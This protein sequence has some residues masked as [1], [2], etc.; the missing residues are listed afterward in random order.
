M[1]S[2]KNTI[3]ALITILCSYTV[4]AQKEIIYVEHFEKVTISPHIEVTFIQGTKEQVTIES[5]SVPENKLTVEVSG[6]SLNIY[7]EGAKMVT[8]SEKIKG[9]DYNKKQSIYTGTIVKATVT[10]KTLESLSLRGEENFVC[11][12]LLDMNHFELDI[13]G[14]SNIILNE[15]K[16]NSNNITMYGESYLEI[17]SGTI[18]KQ[19]IT[20]YGESEVNAVETTTT[21]AKVVAYGEAVV[22][23]N[24]TDNLKVTAYGEATIKYKGNP[25]ISKGI[26][27]GETE[28][29]KIE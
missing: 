18:E 19:K 21:D 4:S 29:R 20:L 7:L 15:V 12:S 27:I 23:L 28:I 1:K 13:Y 16:L 6:K 2:L 11:E 26:V 24:V 22:K 5:I 25:S 8:K 14:E 17:K 9:D 3:I 10:Y